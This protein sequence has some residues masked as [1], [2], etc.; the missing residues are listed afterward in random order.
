VGKR[1]KGGKNGVLLV[2]LNQGLAGPSLGGR[3]LIEREG[4]KSR[5]TLVFVLWGNLTYLVKRYRSRYGG[6]GE[7]ESYLPWGITKAFT[8]VTGMPEKD[9]P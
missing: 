4:Q 9:I 8:L 6:R 2:A 1:G 7:S 3:W 5:R